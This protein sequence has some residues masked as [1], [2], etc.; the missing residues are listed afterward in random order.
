MTAT[1]VPQTD[2]RRATRLL[3]VFRDV[4]KGG[5]TLTTA[6]DAR[7]FLEAIR[8]NES[9]A[10]CLEIITASNAAQNALRHSLRIDS[11]VSFIRSHVLSFVAYLSEPAVKMA[12]NG[13]LLHQ[14]LQLIIQPPVLWGNLF[15][16]YEQAHFNE[17]DLRVFAWLC[18]ELASIQGKD[19]DSIVGDIS[20]ALDQNPFKEAQDHRTRDLT[21]RIKKVLALRSSASPGENLETAGGRHNN[22]FANFREI[23]IFPTSDEFYSSEIPFYRRASE[24]AAIGAADRPRLHL[25]NQFRLLR[26]DM[27]GELRD[28]L[29]VAIGRKRGK[30]SPQILSGLV[31]FGI[32]TGDEKRGRSTALLLHCYSGLETLRPLSLAKR[33]KFL[34]DNKGFLRHQSFGAL[35]GN[36][37]IVAFAFLVRDVDQLVKGP[38]AIALQFTSSEALARALNALQS[39][40]DLRFV[41]VDTPVFAYQPVLEC[42]QDITEMPMEGGLLHLPD[43]DEDSRPKPLELSPRAQA[44]VKI[45]E[46]MMERGSSV[47]GL[48][49]GGK[50]FR[51]DESQ[52]KSVLHALQSP[53]ALI[54]GPPGTGKSFVGALAARIL[55]DNSKRILVLSYTNHALDQFLEDLMNIGIPSGDIV[56]LGSKYTE[57]TEK[58]LLDKQLRSSSFKK[59]REAWMMID[60]AKSDL[61]DIREELQNAFNALAKGKVSFVDLLDALEF[62]DDDQNFYDAFALP[63]QEDGFQLAGGSRRVMSADYLIERWAQGKDAGELRKT[64]SKGSKHIWQLPIAQRHQHVDNWVR[65]LRAEQIETVWR[66]AER[67]NQSQSQLETLFNESK[68][69]LVQ[70]KSVLGCTTTA[71]AKY[72]SLIKAARPDVVLVEEAGEILE[73]HVL[74][75]L[76]PATSQ[77][78]LIGDHKQLRPKINNYTLSVEKGEG[79]DL[80]RSLF[81]RLILQGHEHVT[82]QKQH[83][84]HPEISHL[85]RQMTYPKLQDDEKTFQRAEPR[86][87]QGRVSFINHSHPEDSADEIA[88]RRDSGFTASKKNQFEAQMVLRLVRYLAQQEY[89]T[90]N[91]VVLTPYLGQ[92]RLLRDM[93]SEENDPILNDMDSYELVRAGLLTAAAA[94]VKSGSG[95]I[96]LSTIDNYQ[97]EE[98]DIVIASMTRSNN[99]G[100][101]GFMKAPERL[102]VLCSRARECLIMIGNMETFMKSS[103]GK[104]VWVPFFALLKEKEYLHDGVLV[105]CKQH[106]DKTALLENPKDFDIKCPDGGCDAM[107]NAP[108]S[109]GKHHCQRRCH[110]ISNHSKVPCHERIKKTCDRG[111]KYSVPCTDEKAGCGACLRED[112]DTR[113]RIQR[114]L[115]MEEERMLAQKRYAQELQQ[116][117]DELDHEKRRLKYAQEDEDHKIAMEKARADVEALKQ[118]RARTEAMKTAAEAAKKVPGAFPETETSWSPPPAQGSAREEWDILKKQNGESS[119]ALDDVMDLVGLESVKEEFLSIKNKVDTSVLQNISL[120]KERF[121]CTLL[122]NPGTGK[123]TVARI[124]GK[125][126]TSVGVIAGSSF[127][128]TT[129]SKLANMGVGGCQ[130]MVEKI[131]EDGGGVVFID[132]AYQLSS[133]NSPGGKAVLDF[134]LAEVENLTGRIVFILA[135]YNKQMETF[136]AHNPGF[137]SR[138]PIQMKFDDYNDDELLQILRRQVR[139]KYEGQMKWEDDLYLRIVAR[140]LGRGRGKEGFGNARAVENLLNVISGRQA[141]R[142]RRERKKGKKPDH[143]LFTKEDMIGP[144]PSSALEKCPAWIKLQKLIGLSSVKASVKALVDSIQTNYRRELAEE[145]AIEYS[146][147]KVFLGSPGTGK[148]TV[149]KLYGQILVHLGLLSNDEVIVKNPADFTGAVL[150]GSEAQTKG[151][152]AATVGKVLVIDEAYGL[153]GGGGASGGNT[154]DPYKTAVVDTIV[155]EIQSVPGEDRCVLLLGYRDQMEEMFQNVNPGL[156]RR[157]PISSAFNFEDFSGPEMRQILDLKLKDQAFTATDQAKRVAME[158]L[159]RARNRP[160]FGNAGEIDNVLDQAKIRHQQ[161]LSSNQTTQVSTLEPLDFDENYDRAERTDTNVAKLFEGTVGCE[162]IVEKLQGFQKNVCAMKELGMDPKENIPFNFLFRGPPGTGKTTTARKMGKVFYDMGFLE[163]AKVIECSATDLIGSFVGQT[164]P[165]VQQLLDKALGRV[166]FVDEAYRLAEGGFAKEAVDELVDC[167]TKDKYKGKL[168]IILAGYDNDIN[169]LLSINPGMSSR[170]PEAIQFHPLGP[171]QCFDLLLQLLLRQKGEF[172]A[173]KSTTKVLVDCLHQPSDDFKEDVLMYFSDLSRSS[174]WASAR[175][176]ECVKKSIFNEAMKSRQGTT[177]E[178]TEEIV[179]AELHKMLAE[180]ESRERHEGTFGNIPQLP[181]LQMGPS[182][183]AHHQVRTQQQT[184]TT[185]TAASEGE[186][187]VYTPP[188]SPVEEEVNNETRLVN[189]DD[190]VSDA[191]WAQLELDK[192]LREEKEEEYRVLMKAQTQATDAAREAILKSLLEEDAEKKAQEERDEERRRQIEVRRKKAAAEAAAAAAARDAIRNQMI[193]EERQR[194]KEEEE[195]RKAAIIGQCCAGFEWIKQHGGYRCAGGSHFVTDAEIAS[196]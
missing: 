165:K 67:F 143:W 184:Q 21:Y 116:V 36:N 92:L 8:T 130:K 192:R 131:L 124:Y 26:E 87:L 39:P 112:E 190:G 115:R 98:S 66:L 164:G 13:Q 61:A 56:R 10:A 139:R 28:D 162:A 194:Q 144:E 27:L 140:R 123:T 74:T 19:H 103:Q 122:G 196:A 84:M 156:S 154:S 64:I 4:T 60:A 62:S 125:F 107:C 72:K 145:P 128:E 2:P 159:D 132:E 133:G 46:K 49:I 109:C 142:I 65:R 31:P 127:N 77:L 45:L 134:L 44:H 29:K 158:M 152:L 7:L 78:I 174:S 33:K 136:F 96:K 94:K 80:N 135:G 85:V 86:G 193:K 179:T 34:E 163:N 14:V 176:V 73:A 99:N 51:L 119:A 126:L 114:D 47:K 18:F 83:R 151:I 178:V 168:I 148:T 53:I 155:A 15:K 42:L 160:N 58:L 30:K 57:K 187:I 81:E 186:E 9:P 141:N 183:E 169:R 188:E 71:A 121:G 137:P 97:G 79:F 82:L 111:H 117:K 54:Q 181:T 172:E 108:L 153:Y 166:L 12:Y 185:T 5:R 32:D 41:L 182:P 3:K 91:I 24:L 23:S 35:C 157:F 59:T 147:N 22:D 100:D 11:S 63:E 75:A 43:D 89:K 76:H 118:T 120:S 55:R 180:R 69:S 173:A 101:I 102:N 149:A 25:D 113:R 17:D 177:I 50:N 68:C 93:L 48:A 191:E 37:N 105:R 95:R 6:A 38:P 175:D 161:R 20:S 171:G 104:Q 146:L 195:R 106:P 70:D 170:F 129:G 1:Q 138:F 150:G 88:D 167:V 16:A 52:T 189:R 90:N 40:K 110:P